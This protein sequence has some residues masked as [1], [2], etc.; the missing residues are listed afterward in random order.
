MEIC[1]KDWLTKLKAPLVNL[2]L[3][4]LTVRKISE[5]KKELGNKRLIL[6]GNLVIK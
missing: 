4:F 5:I 1:K 2:I 3:D 6:L